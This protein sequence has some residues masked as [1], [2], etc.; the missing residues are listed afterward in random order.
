MSRPLA[1]LAGAALCALHAPH[2]LAQEVD[3]FGAYGDAHSVESPQHFAL[4]LRLG[5]YRPR[6]DSEFDGTAPYRDVFGNKTR[7]MVGFEFDWQALRLGGVGSL[8]PGF[9]LGYTQMSAGALLAGE[10][11]RASQKTTLSIL[12]LWAA[13]VL[14]VDAVARRT[15]VP[16]ALYA[17]AG[18]A[19]GLWWTDGGSGTSRD[20]DGVVGKGRSDGWLL[21]G[22][23][24][25]DTSFIE[26][27]AARDL[28]NSSGVNH[29]YFFGEWMWLDLGA[30][31]PGDSM[32]VGAN[33]WLGGIAF[34]F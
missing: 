21:A 16:L 2:A 15:A 9:G 34:E 24:M 3:V 11:G 12:P 22:G 26:P 23:L 7:V 33:T 20:A 30:F 28:D 8:G 29:C 18:L 14:R 6:I 5:P 19:T 1:T 25:L 17:K 13:A 10:S 27:S 4:E 32:R 31:S